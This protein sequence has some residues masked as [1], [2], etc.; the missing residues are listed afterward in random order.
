MLQ[1]DPERCVLVL[2][3]QL[4]AGALA[5]SE[6]VPAA[7][8]YAMVVEI[9]M[10]KMLELEGVSKVEDKARK[11]SLML[12]AYELE[13]SFAASK[14]VDSLR[15]HGVYQKWLDELFGSLLSLPIHRNQGGVVSTLNALQEK[16]A[17]LVY[18][19]YDTILDA[20]LNTPPILLSDEAAVRGWATHRTSG[21]LHVHGAHS[22]PD[23]VKCDCVNYRQLVGEA[24]GGQILREVCRNRCVVFLGFDSEFF[25]PFLFK[26][27][28][29]FLSS[30]QT[31]PLLLS[32][33]P[34]LPLL[35]N[36]LTLRIPQ[37]ANLERIFISSSPVSRL[38]EW[39][40]CSV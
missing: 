40:D 5:L 7:L 20:A 28:R 24:S 33:A 19:Y 36:F 30:S 29:A 13:P 31:A 23:S 38:G 3:S 34:K 8:S 27:S 9:G 17:L 39:V 16:G 12:S 37:L 11:Q 15:E 22:Q 25:D 14:V 35:E 6:G 21:L 1:I 2:G 4:A 10:Q 26:F 18:T 32:L